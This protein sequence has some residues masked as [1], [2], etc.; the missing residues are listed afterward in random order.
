MA[1]VARNP[2]PGVIFH[3]DRGA[4]YTSDEFRSFCRDNGVR[5]SVGR[6]GSCFD[7]AVAESFFPTIN[8]RPGP[9]RILTNFAEPC[10]NTSSHVTTR[11]AGIRQSD[12][13]PRSNTKS[14]THSRDDKP[15]NRVSTRS[16]TLQPGLAVLEGARRS[17]STTT[18]RC[19]TSCPSSPSG[20]R[21]R[22]CVTVNAGRKRRTGRSSAFTC[23]AMSSAAPH[24]RLRR[25]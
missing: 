25:V 3:S 19:V 15:C 14:N 9:G 7:N 11:V 1:I 16:G 18:L 2:P 5:P 20:M 17:S 6:T 10:S 13:T 4:Q 22:P 24:T 23:P 12:M 21:A 8:P